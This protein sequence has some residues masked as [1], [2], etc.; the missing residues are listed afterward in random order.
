MFNDQ[1]YA[2]RIDDE[3]RELGMLSGDYS[4][5]SESFVL[6]MEGFTAL[7]NGRE[8]PVCSGEQ[9]SAL[10]RLLAEEARRLHCRRER[11]QVMA[12]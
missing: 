12:A 9:L 11:D 8:L 6:A 1:T 2:S 5:R 10:S 4:L 3:L 7:L